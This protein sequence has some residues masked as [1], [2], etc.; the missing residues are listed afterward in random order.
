MVDREFY[1]K[2]CWYNYVTFMKSINK[3]LFKKFRKN[4]WRNF[5]LFISMDIPLCSFTLWKD[6]LLHCKQKCI[7]NKQGSPKILNVFIIERNTKIY[8]NLSFQNRPIGKNMTADYD[9]N[10]LAWVKVTKNYFW[11]YWKFILLVAFYILSNI[12]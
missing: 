6:R 2:T 4:S 9:K 1:L 3:E 10:K 5:N 12:P 7:C 11:K 8:W